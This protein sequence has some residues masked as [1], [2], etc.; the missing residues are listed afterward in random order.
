MLYPGPS[1]RAQAAVHISESAVAP[2]RPRARTGALRAAN[3]QCS[4]KEDETSADVLR[5]ISQDRGILAINK[6]FGQR[7]DGD[8]EATVHKLVLQRADV[9]KFRPI[10]QV[11]PTHTNARAH[12]HTHPSVRTRTRAHTYV[13]AHAHTHAY[14]RTRARTHTHTHTHTHTARL[15][16][17][18]HTT[19]GHGQEKR[20]ARAQGVGL[21]ARA[22][23]VPGDP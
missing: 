16:D 15:C 5:V 13:R 19:A 14:A 20:R 4:C 22:Q 2:P 3:T 7:M 8:Y 21:G 11:C 1:R 18:R 12:T 17:E 9:D 23:N 10:H 6:R